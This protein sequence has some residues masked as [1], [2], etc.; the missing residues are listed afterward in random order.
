MI[1]DFCQCHVG[2]RR[3]VNNLSQK[4]GGSNAYSDP[5]PKKWV[6]PDPENT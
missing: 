5:A 6:G 1:I 3:V 2:C 4:V